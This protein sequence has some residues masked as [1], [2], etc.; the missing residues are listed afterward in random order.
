MLTVF[1]WLWFWGNAY[2]WTTTSKWTITNFPLTTIN[3]STM[4]TVKTLLTL[5]L[6][7]TRSLVLHRKTCICDNFWC[8]DAFAKQKNSSNAK[9]FPDD[10]FILNLYKNPLVLHSVLGQVKLYFVL[11]FRCLEPNLCGQHHLFMSMLMM[12]YQ[13]MS[14]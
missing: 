2:S 9:G 12:I 7:H 4:L 14:M 1:I 5:V 8:V 3:K 11:P 10:L 6:S 13:F